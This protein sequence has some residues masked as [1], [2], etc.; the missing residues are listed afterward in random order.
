M[1]SL[2]VVAYVMLCGFPPFYHEDEH[3][4]FAMVLISAPQET[5]HVGR[6]DMVFA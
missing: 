5:V 6:S 3:E 2:G 4:M 1:W